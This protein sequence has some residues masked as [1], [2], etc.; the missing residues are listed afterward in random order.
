MVVEYVHAGGHDFTRRWRKQ[1]GSLLRKDHLN[2]GAGFALVTA[3]APVMQT[4]DVAR[5]RKAQAAAIRARCDERLEN[6]IENRVGN[7]DAVVQHLD[8][9]LARTSRQDANGHQAA[10]DVRMV[11]RGDAVDDEIV[12][13]GLKQ[14]LDAL[15]ANERRAHFEPDVDLLALGERL[16]TSNGVLTDLNQAQAFV[17]GRH[18]LGEHAHVLD[19]RRGADRFGF[20]VFDVLAYVFRP[21]H[22]AD[23][24]SCQDVGEVDDG[25][26]RVVEFMGD[27]GRHHAHGHFAFP[28]SA[29]AA[30]V[31][32]KYMGLTHCGH[33]EPIPAATS[34]RTA[35][36]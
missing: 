5:D 26:E 14:L 35:L 21:D 20:Y 30:C 7:T 22:R 9:G 11:E 25:P 4:N 17:C 18:M 19:H 23:E 8:R 28:W 31:A 2:A 12:Q 10:G 32:V 3:Y 15:H 36:Y 33:F 16:H 27:I 24:T 6:L 1:G 13:G 34:Q 29:N